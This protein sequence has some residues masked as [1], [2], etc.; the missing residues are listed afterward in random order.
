MKLAT[1]RDGGRDGR[2]LVVNRALT[3][4]VLATSVAPT[5]Q[6]ALDSWSEN[7]ARLK[8]IF[9][10]LQAGRAPDAFDLDL[11]SLAAPL[12]RAYCWIDS[13]VYLNHLELARSLRGAV[14]PESYRREPIMSLR[15][16]APFLVGYD[17][18]PLP[19]GDI[20]LDIEAEVAVIVNDVSQGTDKATASE[21]IALVTLVNDTSH[22][23]PLAR[24]LGD[25]RLPYLGKAVPAMA[26][27]V[28]TLDEIGTAW[29]GHML[30]R[31][32][33]ISINGSFHGR[34][35]AAVDASFDFADII[36]YAASSRPLMAGTVIA[37]G[38]I[39]NRDSTVGSACI[40]E[41]RMIE[42][43]AHGAPR[44]EFLRDGDR[45]RI[46]VLA[47]DGSSIF[48]AIDQRVRQVDA[49]GART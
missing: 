1:M 34:P 30:A 37:A 35:N 2:L 5:L 26:P 40:A 23:I 19:P 32:V 16:S 4:A 21:R 29:Q 15:V 48:G 31:P 49:S 28:A 9:D 42:A 7:E 6:V 33:E 46:E 10:R 14:V 8:V 27:I 3:R 13:S 44:T 38:T 24:E 43:R 11:S 20:G 39:S 17:D 18:L 41:R 12:P 47:E 45:F 36:R 22:R 25:D